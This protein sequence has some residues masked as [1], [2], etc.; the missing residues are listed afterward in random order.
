[1]N[2]S[3]NLPLKYKNHQTYVHQLYLG[4]SR[5][6]AEHYDDAFTILSKALEY[7]KQNDLP[8]FWVQ[9]VVANALYKLKRYVESYNLFA[10]LAIRDPYSI[11][12]RYYLNNYFPVGFYCGV[13]D[14]TITFEN[15]N[16]ID[17]ELLSQLSP[18]SLLLRASF[19]NSFTHGILA[20]EID[21]L[22]FVTLAL[23]MK[24]FSTD[25][26]EWFKEYYLLN[27]DLIWEGIKRSHGFA[28]DFKY[29]LS[30]N[31][32]ISELFQLAKIVMDQDPFAMDSQNIVDQLHEKILRHALKV[33]TLTTLEQ[34]LIPEILGWIQSLLPGNQEIEALSDLMELHNN[35]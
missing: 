25:A 10:E 35:H 7:A 21:P 28:I 1:M 33:E 20:N 23:S 3:K 2:S 27:Y 8:Y 12:T 34:P 26:R 9:E 22:Q 15:A 24:L 4:T 14:K 29:L 5:W 16:N 6:K 31:L 18:E 32:K 17:P 13:L 11:S 19:G 30:S